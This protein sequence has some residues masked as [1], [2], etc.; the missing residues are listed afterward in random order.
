MLI[1]EKIE[2][3]KIAQWIGTISGVLI[4]SKCSGSQLSNDRQ[5]IVSLI[6]LHDEMCL[7]INRPD[8]IEE[9]ANRLNK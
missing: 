8:W 1:T 6:K 3:Y 5:A 4:G 9:L 2:A 7:C